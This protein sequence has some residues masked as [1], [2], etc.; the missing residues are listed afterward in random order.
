L[1]GAGAEII[2]GFAE[3]TIEGGKPPSMILLDQLRQAKKSE[4]F[5]QKKQEAPKQNADTDMGFANKL[6]QP[7]TGEENAT[8]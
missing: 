2:R 1:G 3:E 5:L 8:R 4:G 6:Q 7:L